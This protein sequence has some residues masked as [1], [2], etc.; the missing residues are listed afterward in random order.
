MLLT[1][2]S[3]K[4]IFLF[5]CHYCIFF[6]RIT[7]LAAHDKVDVGVTSNEDIWAVK[8]INLLMSVQGFLNGQT[9]AREVPV[10]GAPFG[11]DVFIV[12]L[13]DELRFDLDQYT[14]DLS[15]L[16]TRASRYMPS[17][18]QEAQHRVQVMLYKKL[19]D[20]LV[21]GKVPKDLIAKH[22]RVRLDSQFGEGITTHLKSAG[23][24]CNTLSELLDFTYR[25]LQ[26]CTCVNKL[27]IEY[28]F[29]DTGETLGRKEIDY[30]EDDLRQKVVDSLDYWKGRRPPKGVEIEEAW[31]CHRCEF[32][33]T[34]DW[35]Q[36]KT[37]ECVE[38]NRKNAYI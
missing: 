15:D 2:H 24:E 18:S 25:R 37:K 32:V 22:L 23:I 34:C 38:K 20:D 28:V 11:Q 13:I 31:K 10:F 6:F 16:K 36:R 1:Q 9:L 14:V 27:S 30:D 26:S 4:S 19:F 12:G 8:V 3:Y 5:E 7:E 29:Q 35:L 17:K 33:D 21:Q